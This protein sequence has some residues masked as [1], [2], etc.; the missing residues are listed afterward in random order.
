MKKY[1]YSVLFIVLAIIIVAACDKSFL[2]TSPSAVLD[3]E[4]LTD[5]KGVEGLL[6]GA[7]SLLDG[8][9]AGGNQ[10]ASSG[11]NWV[12]GSIV[13]GEANK[14]SADGD[15]PDIQ[16]LMRFNA[17]SNNAY[18][19]DK[20][21]VLYESISR[22][23]KALKV[24]AK[25][26]SIAAAEATIY[27]A[28]L[29]FL[30]GHYHF[31]AKKIW[32]NIPYVDENNTAKILSNTTDVWPKIEADMQ[33]AFD[34]LPNTQP[35]IGRAN[36]W[37]AAAYLAKIKIFRKDFAGAKPILDN[38]I[39][40]GTNSAGVKYDLFENFYDNFNFET[41]NGKEAVFQIQYS[42]NDG[43]PGNENGNY[44]NQLNFPYGTGPVGCCGFFQPSLDLGNSYQVNAQGL[45]IAFSNDPTTGYNAIRELKTDL[46]I[47]SDDAY[48]IDTNA[49]DPRIDWTIGR[50]GIPFL[51]WGIDAGKSWIRD[52]PY[53]GPYSSIKNI[54]R[55]SQKGSGS[56]TATATWGSEQTSAIN[57]NIIR[58]A[59]VLLWAAECEV[60]VGSLT[61]A[62][63]YVNRVRAR[64][65]NPNGF[66][67][68]DDGTN[69][70]NYKIGLYS[71][72][73]FTNQDLA[74][75][76]VRFERKLELAMEGHRFFDLV[77]WNTFQ[78]TLQNYVNYEGSKIQCVAGTIVVKP[79]HN[80][81]AIPL[82]QIDQS[83]DPTGVFLLKQ[84]TGY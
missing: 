68:K 83:L 74:R 48:T 47:E 45:P 35:N 23:N 19:N 1:I 42:V 65:S 12:Y 38:V 31:E 52:Q 57:Y 2:Q 80:Y 10:W 24:L 30:R 13:G 79:T 39:A 25:A 78:T 17:L 51:D 56:G 3:E 67:K 37:A 22:C 61:K 66:V 60:E 29:L 77:R 54:F 43:S 70:A 59:D 33:F 5:K 53:G 84:N 73:N 26:T 27:K 62:K 82:S 8:V 6:V 76:V 40:N 72:A 58:F 44:G 69:A 75:D 55:K 36:K 14:G 9:G 32:N 11:D 4:I 81:F 50:R 20:W 7:Y 49:L 16:P 63:D 34:N 64:A 46:G 21:L 41:S 28:E 71:D 18:P 15:Q